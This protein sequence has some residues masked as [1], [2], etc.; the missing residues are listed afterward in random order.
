MARIVEA[1]LYPAVERYFKAK[2]LRYTDNDKNRR[3][4]L[5]DRR[6]D[7]GVRFPDVYGI[8]NPEVEDFK[9]YLGEGKSTLDVASYDACKGRASALQR[10]ADYVF[11]FFPK[12]DWEQFDKSARA[13]VK[14]ECKTSGLGLLLVDVE[15][16]DCVEEVLAKPNVK[17]LDEQLKQQAK[18]W[19][20]E[21]FFPVFPEREEFKESFD[22]IN[23]IM[24]QC[25]DLIDD[26]R[27]K[28]DFFYDEE[29]HD[30]AV[31][32]SSNVSYENFCFE[33]TEEL[34]EE[35]PADLT[36]RL[37]P[38]RTSRGREYSPELAIVLTLREPS[39]LELLREDAVE[40]L[41]NLARDYGVH[42]TGHRGTEV[43]ATLAIPTDDTTKAS[44]MEKDIEKLLEQLQDKEPWTV[45]I[46][47]DIPVLGHAME[48]I[49]GD[50]QEK[51]AALLEFTDSHLGLLEEA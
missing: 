3:I 10:F 48:E 1:D 30:E 24:E 40:G 11:M 37:T 29:I 44:S 27:W 39:I 36:L 14:E 20:V 7:L 46:D 51:V 43:V 21:P 6:K 42:I 8:E 17:E 47:L 22:S 15:A 13:A 2:D 19:I 26:L 50:T 16:E 32:V 23:R 4:W 18:N 12:S 45:E 31:D 35:P 33:V 25:N 5:K 49:S 41:C 9:V 28:I 34:S 38:F